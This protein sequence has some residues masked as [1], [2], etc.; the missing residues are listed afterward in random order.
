MNRRLLAVALAILA[1]GCLLQAAWGYSHFDLAGHAAGSDDAYISYRY[2]FNLIAGH[3]LVFNPGERV[4]GYT[5]LLYVLLM[6][7]LAWLAGPERLYP[8]S[9]ALNFAFAALAV[10]Q[11]GGF[12]SRRLDGFRGGLAALLLALCP[13]I[14]VAVAS[15]LETPLVLC[16]QVGIWIAVEEAAEGRKGRL[17]LLI[18]LC[19]LLILTRADGFLMPALAA[20]FLFLKGR[21]RG[22]LAVAGAAAATVA[23]LVLW[24][25]SYYGWPLPNTYYAK[26]SGT[27]MARIEVSLEQLSLILS[28]TTG[29]LLHVFALLLLVLELAR[30]REP[31]SAALSFPVLFFL[32]WVGY[33]IYVGGDIFYE[34]FLLILLPMGLFAILSLVKEARPRALA[35]LAVA[36]C[37]FQ[38]FQIPMDSRFDYLPDRYDRWVLLGH[39]LGERHPGE[40]LASD[41]VGKVPYFSGMR[42]IDMLGLTDVHIAHRPPKLEGRRAPGHNKMDPGYV[43]SRRPDLIASWISYSLDMDW[44]LNREVY[45]DAGYRVRYLVNAGP[46]PR[47]PNLIDVAGLGESEIS[48]KVAMGYGY[49]VLELRTPP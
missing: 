43:L 10:I 32:P 24:R 29:L 4:E 35:R 14:W 13:S 42:T 40:I 7:P 27:L 36:V 30:R 23:L 9:V 34:R 44:G 2:A 21:R 48:R 33:W 17:L 15:G 45:E 16:L 38:L 39:Y 31:L 46:E 6:V 5:N 22:A 11:V 20:V 26:V 18:G 8:L 12:I 41:A 28:T 25:L 19:V 1:L 3:G 49:G 47:E 37:A